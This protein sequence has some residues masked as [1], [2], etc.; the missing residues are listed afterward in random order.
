VPLRAVDAGSTLMTMSCARNYGAKGNG[1]R[2]GEKAERRK[3]D[4]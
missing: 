3:A 4:M 1:C 2:E